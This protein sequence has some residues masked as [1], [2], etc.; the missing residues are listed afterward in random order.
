M[1]TTA[2]TQEISRAIVTTW[3]IERVYSPVLD[4]A[5]AIGRGASQSM[6]GHANHFCMMPALAKGLA[7]LIAATPASASRTAALLQ[8]SARVCRSPS[9]LRTS[10]VAPSSA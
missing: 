3:K 1:N 10:H 2:A 6:R 4:A 8:R 5:V 7:R 9:V